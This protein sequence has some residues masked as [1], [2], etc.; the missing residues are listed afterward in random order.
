MT[1]SDQQ[2][3]QAAMSTA[4]TDSQAQSEDNGKDSFLGDERII[5]QEFPGR[6]N[7]QQFRLNNVATFTCVRCTGEKTANLVA[8]REEDWTGGG[9]LYNGCFGW[10]LA[11]ADATRS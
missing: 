10:L 1:P 7:L 4:E 2:Q 6:G 3:D 11:N 5:V 9:F 8:V